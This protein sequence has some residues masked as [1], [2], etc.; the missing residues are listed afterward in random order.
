MHN[1]SG[2]GETYVRFMKYYPRSKEDELKTK[3]VWLK[4][5]TDFGT[6]TILYSQPV[7]ALQILTPDGNWKWVKHIENALVSITL[8]VD[9][10]ISANAIQVINAGDAM[11]FLSG[12]YYRATI[13]R[14]VQPPPDQQSYTRLGVF[15]FAMTDDDVELAPLLESPVLQRAGIT[16]EEGKRPTMK[17]WRMGRTAAYGQTDLVTKGVENGATK[18]PPFLGIGPFILTSYI[19]APPTRAELNYADLPVIDLSLSKTIEG[20]IELSRLVHDAMSTQGF[21]YVVNHGLCVEETRRLFDIA[22][23]VFSQMPDEEKPVYA[24]NIEETGSYQGYKLRQYWNRQHIDGGVRD[25]IEHYNINRDIISR[26]HPRELQP[27]LPE[28]EDFARHNHENVLHP[29]L[30]LFALG[31][32][33]PENT[34]V[35]LHNYSVPGETSDIGTVTILYSQPVAGL[36]ILTPEGEWKWLKHIE[37]A[38]VINAG[39]V[40]EL[41]VVSP[42]PDQESYARLG[43]FYFAMADD[44]VV[45]APFLGSPVLRCKGIQGKPGHSAPRASTMKEW[46]MARTLSYG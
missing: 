12:G 40:M 3:N 16:V 23:V 28:I 14:V 22:D 41:L 17:E 10:F 27:Y 39:D 30:K 19:P 21:F 43:V 32:E 6:I 1:Y 46:R 36:Q 34:F 26:V 20:C 31:L 8:I 45:L 38:L 44:D 37:N 29:I 5:H 9:P 18:A 24:A 42:P 2:V 33:L 7:A 35:D 25:Q 15:Y 13:H 11:Q 4:G